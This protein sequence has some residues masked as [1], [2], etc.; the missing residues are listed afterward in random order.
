MKMVSISWV[1]NEAD[2]IE[3]FVRHHA[4]L[5]ERMVIVDNDSEDGTLDILRTL[6]RAGFPLEIR[7]DTAP[8]HRQAAAL[9]DLLHELATGTARPDWIL[10]LDADEF[11]AARDERYIGGILSILPQNRVT[12]LPWQTYVPL[13]S[14]DQAETNPIRRIR[15]RRSKE[16][17]Q[18]CKVLIPRP[19]HGEHYALTAGNHEIRCN[20]GAPPPHAVSDYLFLAHFPVRSA[21]QI[22]RKA[23]EGRW[24]VRANPERQPNEGFHW[25]RMADRFRRSNELSPF[26]LTELAISYGCTG[27]TPEDAAVIADPLSSPTPPSRARTVMGKENTHPETHASRPAPADP[28]PRPG[29]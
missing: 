22:L 26:D 14:E 16:Q 19:F 8:F 3:A 25:E 28:L 13:P 10:P 9:T 2:I 1:R 17:P 21:L 12:L 24:R 18:Y 27:K 29:R 4:P 23:T 15:H 20:A 6:A 5:V 7:Q 11:L